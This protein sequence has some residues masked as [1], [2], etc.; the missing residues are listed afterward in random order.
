MKKYYVVY[1]DIKKRPECMIFPEYK[2]VIGDLF[3]ETGTIGVT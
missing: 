1:V 2:E 3:F